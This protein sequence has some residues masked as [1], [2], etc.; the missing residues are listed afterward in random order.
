MN[1]SPQILTDTKGET[2]LP[3]YFAQVFQLARDI[4]HGQ[5]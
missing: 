5:L 3:R 4:E 1:A 2:G